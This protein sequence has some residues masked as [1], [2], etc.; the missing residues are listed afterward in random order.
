M[1]RSNPPTSSAATPNHNAAALARRPRRQAGR[2]TA[3]HFLLNAAGAAMVG[4]K[5]WR[6]LARGAALSRGATQRTR[7]GRGGAPACPSSP[8]PRR[9]APVRTARPDIP[10]R[11][12]E[13]LQARGDPAARLMGDAG[14][15]RARPP[16]P[17]GYVRDFTGRQ[18]LAAAASGTPGLSRSQE[19]SRRRASSGRN[20]S[21]GARGGLRR[22][23]C[24][25]PRVGPTDGPSY[26][27]RAG[28]NHRRGPRRRGH[29]PVLRQGLPLAQSRCFRRADWGADWHPPVINDGRRTTTPPAASWTRSRRNSPMAALI[30]VHDES[31]LERPRR[32]ANPPLVGQ[33]TTVTIRDPSTPTSARDGTSRATGSGGNRACYVGAIGGSSRPPDGLPRRER[34]GVKAIPSS[35]RA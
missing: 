8:S 12:I 15:W 24:G 25:V 1:A 19:A 14:E 2:P 3:R 22:G 11:A 4:P 29:L 9:W 6:A 34:P 16:T 7:G 17:R 10:R 18:L 27:G 32:L 21:S 28:S 5:R 31:D 33:S 30:E 20:R 26:P 23:R 35:A 13:G